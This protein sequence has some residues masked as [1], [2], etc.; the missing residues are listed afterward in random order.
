MPVEITQRTQAAATLIEDFM[1]AANV[2]AAQA[3]I[4]PRYAYFAFM[5]SLTQKR[6]RGRDLAGRRGET[7]TRAGAPPTPFQRRPRPCE[8]HAHEK[9]INEAVLRNQSKAVYSTYNIG[10][11]GLALRDYAF[12]LADTALCRP[13][14]ASCADRHAGRR[15]GS[16]RRAWR[17]RRGG[18]G[19]HMF[20]FRKRKRGPQ[21]Q[22][23]VPSTDLRQRCFPT[24][25]A[26]CSTGSYRV[27]PDRVLSSAWMTGQLTG[28]FQCGLFDDYYVVNE[29]G[30]QMRGRHSG[31]AL[32]VGDTIEILVVDVT[33]VS[34][35]ILLAYGGG[36]QQ[37]APPGR[38]PR[39]PV[40]QAEAVTSQ[41]QEAAAA[42]TA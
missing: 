42:Q 36:S 11:F 23:D 12:H 38:V 1:I 37:D 35:G 41:G 7:R 18:Y 5:T 19:R 34:G 21:A 32:S 10:H 8:E 16:P 14:G 27:S 6:Q 13:A 26:R 24:E 15:Q 3:L 29:A 17:C 30:M 9:M 33:P 22:K 31:L 2:A 28:F 39:S 20:S 4:A 40:A 25:K